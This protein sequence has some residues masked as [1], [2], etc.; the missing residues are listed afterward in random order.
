MI[1][2]FYERFLVEITAEKLEKEP[3]TLLLCYLGIKVFS[4]LI[5]IW[6]QPHETLSLEVKKDFQASV[7]SI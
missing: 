5:S 2:R 7:E 1:K 4:H 3:E 6:K